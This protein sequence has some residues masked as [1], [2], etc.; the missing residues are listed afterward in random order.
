M[1][2]KVEDFIPATGQL[3]DEKL[4]Q[5][6]ANLREARVRAIKAERTEATSGDL[7]EFLTAKIEA[8]RQRPIEGVLKELGYKG[9]LL[10][11]QLMGPLV[12]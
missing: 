5:L 8:T 3:F 2:S 7:S 6:A 1:G 4:L 11:R 9:P 12:F 10:E